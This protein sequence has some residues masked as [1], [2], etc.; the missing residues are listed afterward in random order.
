MK[1]ITERKHGEGQS[2]HRQLERIPA[3]SRQSQKHISWEEWQ[4][5]SLT[6]CREPSEIK[7]ERI[8]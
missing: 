4:T 7:G 3:E 1:E 5:M 2:L 6:G 8:L